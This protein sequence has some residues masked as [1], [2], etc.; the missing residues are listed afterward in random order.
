MFA[1]DE[2]F[3][4]SI[5]VGDQCQG[6][7]LGRGRFCGITL[8]LIALTLPSPVTGRGFFFEGR[9]AFYVFEQSLFA[10]FAAEAGFAVAA[11]AARGV[12]QVGA[13]DPDSAGLDLRGEV[14]CQVDVLAPDAGG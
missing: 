4:C 14:E 1:G 10:A 6:G 7:G 2:H 13:V 12:E 8:A 11:E 9:F 5:D 3:C